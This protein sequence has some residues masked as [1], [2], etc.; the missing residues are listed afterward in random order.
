MIVELTLAGASERRRGMA[1]ESKKRE[2]QQLLK[3]YRAW[4]TRHGG[5]MPLD[6]TGVADASYGPAGLIEA[7]QGFAK[8]HRTRLAKTYRDLDHALKLLKSADYDLWI[9]LHHP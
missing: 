4:H 2:V 6:E 9:A 8:K 3:D 7:G 5:A 1:S